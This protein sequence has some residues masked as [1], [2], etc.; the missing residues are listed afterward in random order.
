MP[1]IKAVFPI[2]VPFPSIKSSGCT[3]ETEPNR[4]YRNQPPQCPFFQT[5]LPVG[6]GGTLKRI[7]QESAATGT[8]LKNRDMERRPGLEDVV[9]R[10]SA[11]EMHPE[12]RNQHGEP[13]E[14]CLRAGNFRVGFLV[15]QRRNPSGLA[16]VS[17]C[18]GD[19]C[20]AKND[21]QVQSKTP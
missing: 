8:V 18:E 3:L 12:H 7:H 13:K 9:S 19:E 14:C 20:R 21:L 15:W 4:P 1:V 16:F 2:N 11:G 6:F 17:A 10:L 5:F